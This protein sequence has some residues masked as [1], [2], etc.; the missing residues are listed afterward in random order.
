MYPVYFT[1]YLYYIDASY[2]SSHEKGRRGEGTGVREGLENAS[3][4]ASTT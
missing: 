3:S 2:T 4:R 1:K